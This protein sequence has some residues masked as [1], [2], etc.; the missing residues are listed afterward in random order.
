MNIKTVAGIILVFISGMFYL[1]LAASVIAI[2]GGGRIRDHGG[3]LVEPPPEFF[4]N[5]I[6][7]ALYGI[8]FL[9]SGIYL[10][11]KGST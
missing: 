1:R 11:K 8:S 6:I 4:S 7:F 9:V 5:G 10:I 2:F 3:N